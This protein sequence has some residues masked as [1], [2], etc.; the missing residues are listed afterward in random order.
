MWFNDY[1]IISMQGAKSRKKLTKLQNNVIFITTF[2]RLF[3]DA[4]NRYKFTGLPDTIDQRVLLESLCVYGNATFFEENGSLLCL[5]SVPSGKGY[6]MYGNPTSSWVFSR[7]G[8]FNKEIDLFIEGGVNA[9]VLEKGTGGIVSSSN[10][11]GVMVWETYSRYPFINNTIYYAQSIADTLRT[12]DVDRK[13]LK[14]P[15]I[16]VCEESLVPSVKKM[17]DSMTD[18]DDFIPVSTGVLDITKFDLKPVEISPDIVKSASEL[19]EWYE[20]KYRELCGVHSNTQQDKK[21]ENLISDEVHA[22]DEYTDKTNDTMIEC[23]QHYLDIVNKEFNT[24]IRVE[25]VVERSVKTD[26]K[27]DVSR[28]N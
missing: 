7:N 20:N 18:N 17:F 26:E 10:K 1:F 11:K 21:G 6:N 14:R 27:Q 25:R 28:D 3:N 13:W 16:P 12:I 2:M 19:V 24:N 5:P 9:P 15:F 4:I 22:N 23:I 8:L